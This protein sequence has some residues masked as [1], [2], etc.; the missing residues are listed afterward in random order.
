MPTKCFLIIPDGEN[1]WIRADRSTDE[2]WEG[3][4]LDPAGSMYFADW[5]HYREE[6]EGEP[7]RYGFDW[8]NQFTP[9]LM[10]KTPGGTW[11]ID[12]RA[13]NCTRKDDKLHRCWRRHGEPP[14]ITV[15]KAGGDT[16]G[17]GAGSI[18]C[19]DYH[20]FLQNG[21]LT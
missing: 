4:H 21:V 3:P 8:D 14:N 12:S 6:K 9:P 5:Y 10:V 1:R 13:S 19:G 16:C 7:V 2:V 17:A 20:G 11:D 18:Q 15:D